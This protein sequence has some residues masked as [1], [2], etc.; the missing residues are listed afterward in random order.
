MQCPRHRLMAIALATLCLMAPA[1]A[2]VPG[3]VSYQG[4]L[5]DSGG[6]P[7]TGPVDLDFDLFDV[8]TGGT[9]VWSESHTAVDVLD[10]VYDVVL[11]STAPITPALV[12]G[13]ALWLEVTVDGETLSPR[14]RLLAVPYAVRADTAENAENVGGVSNLFIT[15]LYQ[16]F[17]ADGGGPANDDP[18]EGVAD[19]DGDGI[20]NFIDPDNDDDG[21]SDATESAQGS[22]INLVTPT[23]TLIAPSTVDGALTTR[24]SVNGTNFEAGMAATFGSETPTLLGLTPTFFEFDI[25][26]AAVSSGAAVTLA[27]GQSALASFEIVST[28]PMIASISPNPVPTNDTT[29]VLV[30]GENFVGGAS[31]TLDGVP[32]TPYNYTSTSFNLDVGPSAAGTVP[33]V[34]TLPDTQF[35]SANLTFET[36]QIATAFVTS[37]AY[38]GDLGGIAGADAKCAAAASAGSLSGT[39]FAWIS[40]GVIDPESRFSRIKEWRRTDGATIADSWNDLTDGTL[41]VPIQYDEFGSIVASADV[42]TNVDT[43]GVARNAVH[44]CGAWTTNAVLTGR[45]GRADGTTTTT[46]WTDGSGVRSCN[47]SLRLYCFEQ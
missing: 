39:Y 34:I 47:L 27:N 45:F 28:V 30:T 19:T 18:S 29:T 22:D 9:S 31:L 40:D 44:H 32:V 11:G 4:L 8:A 25:G 36:P 7:I 24:V 21:I 33:L 12:S 17:N 10:G 3:E 46:Q 15:E 23:I 5:L 6:Q 26:P 16:H 37:T 2:A 20:A 13:G 41:D 43:A 14:Q 38:D 35:A 42:W 1:G